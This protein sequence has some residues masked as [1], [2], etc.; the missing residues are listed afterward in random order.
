MTTMA[1]LTNAG[2]IAFTGSYALDETWAAR[3]WV[4]VCFSGA[5]I[6]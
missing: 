5:V 4:F 3:V 6:L 1:V 2:I